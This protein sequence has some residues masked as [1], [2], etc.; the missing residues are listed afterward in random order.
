MSAAGGDGRLFGIFA[1]ASFQRP[2]T[3]RA[4]LFCFGQ[5]KELF[6]GGQ[7][8]RVATLRRWLT[9]WSPALTLGLGGSGILKFLGTIVTGLLL[10]VVS[11]AFGC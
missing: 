11:K 2:A 8:A 4:A 1:A 6:A 5:V 10:G 3:I 7:R 9:G